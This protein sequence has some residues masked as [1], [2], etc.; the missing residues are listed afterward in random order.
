[1]AKKAATATKRQRAISEEHKA[2][3]A[4]GRE[5]GRVVRRYL[6]ALGSQRPK[7]RRRPTPESISARLA[8]IEEEL[9]SADP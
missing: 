1:M 4:E 5:Q 9:G 3:L 8:A 7:W 2:A 6:E